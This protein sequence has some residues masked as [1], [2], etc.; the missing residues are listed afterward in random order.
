MIHHKKDAVSCPKKK[1]CPF[2]PT[3][4][5]LKLSRENGCDF[6][7]CACFRTLRQARQQLICTSRFKEAVFPRQIMPTY[8][9]HIP[10]WLLLL[11]NLITAPLDDPNILNQKDVRWDQSWQPEKDSLSY[12]E[13]FQLYQKRRAFVEKHNSKQGNAAA[14]R[15][16][17]IWKPWFSLVR[18]SFKG[19]YSYT[20]GH[21]GTVIMVTTHCDL[22]FF[23]MGI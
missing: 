4:A 22:Q 9:Q 5:A 8:F 15:F 10:T 11:D 20:G 3:K 19:Q 17:K 21:I 12:N 18:V 14:M 1:S 2:L 13:R 16:M 6:H 7:W 23:I